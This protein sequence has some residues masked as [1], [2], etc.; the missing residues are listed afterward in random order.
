[1]AP[2]PRTVVVVNPRS[3]SGALGRQWPDVADKLRRAVAFEEV[4]TRAPGDAT[5]LTREAL[6]SGAERIV[7]VGGDGTINE[8]VNGFFRD[9]APIAPGAALGV[10]PFGTG[11]DFRKTVHLPKRVDDAAAVLA[12]DARKR[13]DVG[14]LDYVTREGAPASRM[15]INIASFGVSGLVDR[16][17][18]ESSKRLGGRATFLLASARATLQYD[19]QRVRMIFD[20]DRVGAVE[21]TIN[22]VAVANGRYFGGGM[23]IA[24]EAELDD[25]RFDVVALG[26]FGFKDFLLSGR[27]IYAG[28][29]LKMDKVSHRRATVVRAEPAN[30]EI[31]ELDVDGETPGVLPATFTIVPRSLWLV[32]PAT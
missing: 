8:V 20:N 17:V 18:N 16:L 13:I 3:Q 28:T 29:H 19:N 31:V 22:T 24:P 26:D 4:H 21:M 7:A 6:E 9:G 23:Y 10:V 2:P 12:S 1:M 11:G 25:G 5:R 14:R 27:R 32:V 15:F 30:G